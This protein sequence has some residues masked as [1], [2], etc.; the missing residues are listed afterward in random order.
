MMSSPEKRGLELLLLPPIVME[1][2]R[3]GC[4]GEYSGVAQGRRGRQALASWLRETRAPWSASASAAA[5]AC[6]PRTRAG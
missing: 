1:R 5:R 3:K 4:R 6:R 2:W